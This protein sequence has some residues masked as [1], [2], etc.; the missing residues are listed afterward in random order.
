MVELLQRFIAHRDGAALAMWID[1]DLQ[2]EPRRQV[3]LER[4]RV[5]VLRRSAQARRALA[6]ALHE[7]LRLPYVEIVRD[8]QIGEARSI[9]GAKQGAGVAGGQLSVVH[10]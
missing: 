6:V 7:P 4:A 9:C 10:E 8:D 2:A 1:R 3:A 5:G